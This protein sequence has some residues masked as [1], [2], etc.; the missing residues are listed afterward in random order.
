MVDFIKKK[1]K[2]Q[3]NSSI[4]WLLCSIPGD[5]FLKYFI[6]FVSLKLFENFLSMNNA[7]FYSNVTWFYKNILK[8]Y[9]CLFFIDDWSLFYNCFAVVLYYNSLSFFGHAFN[10]CQ[11]PC[12]THQLFI[13]I[14]FFFDNN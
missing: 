5:S 3:R 11:I 6:Q 13:I 14:F 4:Q 10:D 9:S 8:Y 7:F 12:S 1:T 2:N